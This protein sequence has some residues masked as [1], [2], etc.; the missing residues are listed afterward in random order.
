[1]NNK[2]CGCTVQ[3][4]QEALHKW[5]LIS[6]PYLIYCHPSDKELIVEALGDTQLIEAIPFIEKGKAIVI[7]RAKWEEEQKKFYDSFVNYKIIGIDDVNS[8]YT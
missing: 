4:I 5:D 6:H 7:D 8:L 3:D 2:Q 1:M